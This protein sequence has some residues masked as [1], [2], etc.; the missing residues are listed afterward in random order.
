M[1]LSRGS[2]KIFTWR[3]IPVKVHWL[4]LV[5]A[6]FI[7]FKDKEPLHFRYN[8]AWVAILFVTVLIHEFGHALTAQKL[9]GTAHQI[10]L[11]PLGGLAYTSHPHGLR[12]SLKITLAGPLTHIPLAVV[13]ASSAVALGAPP[14]PLIFSPF[15]DHIP[16]TT[17][18][19][20]VLI[21]GVKVQIFLLLFNLFVPAY[22]LD[23]G[24]AIVELML[25]RG[26]S[27]QKTAKVIIGMSVLVSVVM[28]VVFK[29]VIIALFVLFETYRL[30]TLSQANQLIAH[31]LFHK[32]M[33]KG[34]GSWSRP[35]ATGSGGGAKVLSLR[36]KRKEKE[37]QQKAATK[38][39]PTC[40][41]SLPANALMCGFCEKEV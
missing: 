28:L 14:D 12:E 8:C 29:L 18:W 2:F 34:R 25:L 21:I 30:H 15:M 4:L 26:H 1:D 36:K 23:C 13:F 31:P 11:W 20:A 7:I 22:P 19:P 38:T 27:P 9:G 3:G 32:A 10:I 35:A 41:R 6:L 37:A 16:S 24:H 39:C 17:F 33:Q 40:K 5:L